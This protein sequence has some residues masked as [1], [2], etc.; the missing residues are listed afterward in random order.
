MKSHQSIIRIKKNSQIQNQKIESTEYITEQYVYTETTS[1]DLIFI[2][3][4]TGFYNVCF[5]SKTLKL[6]DLEANKIQMD[7]MKSILPDLEMKPETINEQTRV[8]KVT[9]RNVNAIV[10]A[11]IIIK[12]TPALIGTCYQ[13]FYN[14]SKQFAFLPVALEASEIVDSMELNINIQ[15]SQSTTKISNVQIEILQDND[16]LKKFETI[17]KYALKEKLQ[18]A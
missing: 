8:L 16:L 5:D 17:S 7:K 10:N 18:S 2:N 13:E 4:P 9:G 6:M 1:K 3:K 15:G 11:S 14:F 12:K